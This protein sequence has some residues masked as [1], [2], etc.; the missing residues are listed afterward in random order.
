M[1]RELSESV[2]GFLVRVA[3]GRVVLVVGREV[4]VGRVGGIVRV[5]RVGLDSAGR[6]TGRTTPVVRGRGTVAEGTAGFETTAFGR[7]NIGS[8]RSS[9]STV[10]PITGKMTYHMRT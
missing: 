8:S 4:E 3:V 5:G 1:S 2:D 6:D 9:S 7:L 10:S